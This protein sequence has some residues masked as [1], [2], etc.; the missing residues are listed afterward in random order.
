MAPTESGV[1]SIVIPSYNQRAFLAE[2]VVS[3]LS[4]VDV[5]VIVVDDGST[6]GTGKLAG[7]FP[8]VR[9][10][11]QP[12]RGVVAARNAGLHVC[13]GEFVLF[14]DADDRL[15]PGAVS[16]LRETLRAHPAA[17]FAY[18]AVAIMDARGRRR[19]HRPPPSMA[20]PYAALLRG[21]FILAPGS[22]LYRRD[23]LVETGGFRRGA[24][25][26]ADYDVYLRLARGRR[27]ARTS[28]VVCDYRSHAGNMSGQPARMLID[29]LRVHAWQRSS[30]STPEWDAAWRA[31][32][33]HWREFYGTQLV[34]QA[35]EMWR[36]R[37]VG[38]T[39]AG[40]ALLV[41]RAP[42]VFRDHAVKKLA[43]A[44]GLRQRTR[45]TAK[46]PSS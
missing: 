24:D 33:Q 2:A 41:L 37:H 21:N 11:R 40:L 10:M 25:A 34:H 6:D 22:V 38:R 15:R 29:T 31:G 26:A 46:R 13:R 18:G 12:N 30:A 28:A 35:R 4:Q 7:R 9:W 8:Q 17:P 20:D 44:V 32:R 45:Y 27:V 1:V 23:Q 36:T 14:L 39:V 43:L 19:A 42:G 3:A 16:A 5:E